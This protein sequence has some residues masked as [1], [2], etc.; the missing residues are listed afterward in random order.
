[1][2]AR[3]HS[4]IRTLDL[5]RG[6][7]V[8]G[9]LAVNVANFAAAPSA[10]YS[11][12]L[13]QP[14]SPADHWAYLGVL[15]FFEGK[16]RALFSIL[17]GAS[18][19]LFVERADA[20]GRDGEALQLRRLA[21]LA[22][23]GL[24]HYLLLWHGDILF[25]YAAVGVV[26]LVLRR[27]PPVALIASALFLFSIWQGIN[28]MQWR[29]ALAAEQA[30]I[31]GTATFA[32]IKDHTDDLAYYRDNDRTELAALDHSWTGL[33]AYKLREKWFMP[34]IGLLYVSGET[35]TYFLFGMALFKR[36]LYT[37]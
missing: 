28:W 32:Q 3:A 17:F 36:E 26:A 2:E 25:L 20:A 14:G 10:S 31:A 1:V 22:G 6:I 21:W 11:P 30:V 23:F 12:D 9:I 24:L 27:A 4:R 7:A 5:I 29:P 18:L 35:L 16:M 33:I 15:V 8:L 37:L 34:L 13:P 19:T